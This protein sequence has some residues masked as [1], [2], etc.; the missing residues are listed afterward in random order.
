MFDKFKAVFNIKSV[1][2]LAGGL[3]LG[4]LFVF[5]IF[6]TSKQRC[7]VISITISN[8]ETHPFLNEKNILDLA[9]NYQVE[10]LK[11]KLMKD[12]DLNDIEK[13]IIKNKLIESCQVHA[14]ARNT[15]FIDVTLQEPVGRYSSDAGI[16]G[17]YVNRK[18]NTFQLSNQFTD[19]VLIL[20]GKYFQG[21]QNIRDKKYEDDVL[22]FINRINEE[23]FWK[24][25][26][27]QID[28]DSLRN[29]KIVPLVGN[30]IVDFGRP[31]DIEEKLI[32]LKY[33]YKNILADNRY[34]HFKKV[35]V[36]FQDQIV[37]E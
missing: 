27:T 28:I 19:R 23:S 30:H 5:S 35:S 13:R 10:I 7:T 24:A 22:H 34:S 33:F 25:Q 32:K 8:K 36:K 37:C 17:Y 29:I 9:T 3:V 31:I 12:I 15:L 14:G 1:W 18:G 4:G 21:K 26:I 16:G 20:S 6:S 2:L 11:G